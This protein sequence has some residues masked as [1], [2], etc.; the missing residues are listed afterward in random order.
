MLY[1]DQ[2]NLG[3]MVRGQDAETVEREL[4]TTRDNPSTAIAGIVADLEGKNP[5]EVTP[6][7]DCIDGTLDHLFSN[8]PAPEAEIAISFTYGGYR[9]TVHQDGTAR[10]RR[11]D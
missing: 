10:F 2:F 5:E 6:I 9:I 11:P 3:A 1:G 4:D 7:W 8:P